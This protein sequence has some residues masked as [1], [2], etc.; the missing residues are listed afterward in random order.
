M[1]E[2]GTEKEGEK[3]SQ[4]TAR[5]EAWSQEPWDHDLSWNQESGHLTNWATP[6]PQESIS[7][8]H[9]PNSAQ[10]QVIADTTEAR[11]FSAPVFPLSL[12]QP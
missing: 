5:L 8:K 11:P 1:S 2:G 9:K 4:H 7:F 10:S 12:F 6:E 3:K